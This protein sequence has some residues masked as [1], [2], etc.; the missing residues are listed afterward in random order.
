[1]DELEGHILSQIVLLP[2][3]VHVQDI[4][5]SSS[6]SK[7]KK[8]ECNK[9]S[10]ITKSHSNKSKKKKN[11]LEILSDWWT[12]EKKVPTEWRLKVQTVEGKTGYGIV[13]DRST[14]HA[15]RKD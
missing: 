1:M 10:E 4:Y 5:K 15:G 8:L 7:I 13:M 2:R 6:I 3:M 11:G 9:L 14:I 12:R